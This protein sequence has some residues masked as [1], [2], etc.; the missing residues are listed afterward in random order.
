M[1]SGLLL[2]Q[3]LSVVSCG[4]LYSLSTLDHPSVLEVSVFKVLDSICYIFGCIFFFFSVHDSGA[5]FPSF[6]FHVHRLVQWV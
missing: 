3:G 2:S 4:I 1:A 5:V 6:S